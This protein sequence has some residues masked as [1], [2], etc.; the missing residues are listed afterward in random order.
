MFTLILCSVSSSF[1]V[2]SV[3]AHP[4]PCDCLRRFVR[5]LLIVLDMV[6]NPSFLLVRACT[7]VDH[8]SL[9]SFCQANQTVDK[10]YKLFQN[11]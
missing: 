9:S 6:Q 11:A 8:G 4:Q 5:A 10:I 2:E 7:A 1:N 3:R